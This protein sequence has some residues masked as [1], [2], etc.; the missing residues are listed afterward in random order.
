MLTRRQTL[1][2]LLAAAAPAAPALSEIEQTLRLGAIAG[3]PA[4]APDSALGKILI[5]ALADLGYTA[6]RN[7][8][9][10][11]RG[12]MAQAG[13]LPGLIAE[14]KAQGAQIFI[15]AGYPPA[16]AAKAA[17]VPTV[18]F[19][20]AGDPVATGLIES[21]AHPGGVVTG[22]SDDAA[23]L[24]VKRLQLLKAFLPSL[25]RVAML[26]NA[27][28]RAM[29][30][31]YEASAATAQ[32]QGLVVQP[33]G[34][35]EPDDFNGAFE[36]M[37]GD[38]PDAILMVS[39]ALMIL[40][41]KRVFDFAAARRLPAIYESDGYAR[42]GGLMSYGADPRESLTRAASMI[43]QI[44]KGAKPGDIPFEQPTRYLFVV[45]LKTAKAIGLEPPV[46]LLALADEVIE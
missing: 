29:T 17:G 37:D 11:T 10:E 26:W 9:F 33:H 22:I 27:D 35:R 15:A 2:A 19:A 23:S 42:D 4:M 36:A 32:T 25:K 39:D 7:L 18:I 30:L 38:K 34:V 13:K 3:G 41:R 5:G 20:G 16:A 8:S 43:D 45:N 12:A 21:W 24:T 46:T 6:G 28:D 40:N 14:L 31:R 44:F 1:I